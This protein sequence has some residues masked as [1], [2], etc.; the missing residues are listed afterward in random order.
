MQSSGSYLKRI[1]IFEI[2]QLKFYFERGK[3]VLE[4]GAGAS[5]QSRYLSD[6]GLLVIAVDVE[7]TNYDFRGNWSVILYD[8][9]HLP[10]ADHSVDMVFSSNV[11]EHIAHVEAFQAEIQRVMKPNSLAI[12]LMPSSTWRFWTALTK[13]V[14]SVRRTSRKVRSKVVA[15]NSLQATDETTTVRQLSIKER[16]SS[17]LIPETHG[18]VG[19]FIT[20]L[21]YFSRRRWSKLFTETGWQIE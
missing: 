15:S 13:Y 6:L 9:H 14:D 20:E 11:L 5:W 8:G 17:L 2:E 12:H 21:Y 18:E 19:N 7:S 1:R 10:V 16:L 3:T 4:I